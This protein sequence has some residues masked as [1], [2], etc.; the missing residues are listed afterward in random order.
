MTYIITHLSFFYVLLF[1]LAKS[2]L[3]TV[4]CTLGFLYSCITLSSSLCTSIAS[5][6]ALLVGK[7]RSLIAQVL[8]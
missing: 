1:C 5:Y 3:T 8:H 4:V 2:I 7:K 6:E